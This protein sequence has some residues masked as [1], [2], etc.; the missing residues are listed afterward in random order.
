MHF[1]AKIYFFQK[2]I[3]PKIQKNMYLDKSNAKIFTKFV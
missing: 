3:K 2:L 1:T